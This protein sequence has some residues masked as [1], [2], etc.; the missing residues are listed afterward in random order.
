[1]KYLSVKEIAEKWNVSE[2]SVRNYC[3]EGRVFGA[4]LE[5]KTWNI[6]ENAQKPERSNKSTNAP[7]NLLEVLKAEKQAQIHGG[8]YHKI[9]IE[10]AYNSNHIE[11]SQLTHD[12]TRLIFETKTIG[13]PND[14]SVYVNDVIE[15]ATHFMCTDEIIESAESKLTEKFIKALHFRLKAGTMESTQK[16]FAVGDYKKVPNEVGGKETTSPE[17]VTDEM[18]KLLA[19]YNSKEQI[20]LED[21]IEFHVRFERIHPFQDGNGRIG[22]L[23][24]FKECLKHNIVPFVIED[25]FKLFYYRGL[26]EWDDERNYLISTCLA[27]QDIFKQYLDYFRIPYKNE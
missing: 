23:I 20:T 26:N 21:I 10:L 6:P 9:Q 4:F 5:G 13:I 25:K 11:G 7:K 19:W 16:W 12:Q 14:V 22:R 2:R 3:A 17:N 15:A 27:A 1:M 24:M 8:I 18:K